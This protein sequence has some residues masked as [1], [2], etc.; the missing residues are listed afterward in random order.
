MSDT[1]KHGRLLES[2]YENHDEWEPCTDCTIEAYRR[3]YIPVAEL[4]AYIEERIAEWE[5]TRFTQTEGVINEFNDLLARFC[6]GGK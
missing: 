3:E 5:P 2:F 1:C 4:K 6:N